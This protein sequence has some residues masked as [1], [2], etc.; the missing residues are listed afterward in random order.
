MKIR[1][2]FVSNS[3]SSSFIISDKTFKS[4][5]DIATYMINRKYEKY[6][7]DGSRDNKYYKYMNKEHDLYLNMLKNIDENKP[8]TFRSCNYDTYIKKV[9]DCYLVSTCNNEDWDLWQF[10]TKLTEDA[11][12]ELIKI[13]QKYKEDNEDDEDD[14]NSIDSLL[15]D[16]NEFYAFDNDYYSLDFQIIGIESSESC[17]KCKKNNDYNLLWNTKKHGIICPI[18]D[19]T[20]KRKDKLNEIN[21]KS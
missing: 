16:D 17:P 3:S 14:L 7:N 1:T 18:C 21:K 4:V 8:V 13:R 15:E 5:R 10:N 6:I 11:K 2:G 19:N 20:Y 9:A 12:S